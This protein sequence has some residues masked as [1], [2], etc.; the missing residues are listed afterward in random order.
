[1]RR[2]AAR[3]DGNHAEIRDTLRACGCSVADLSHVGGGVPDLLVGLRGRSYCIEV[4]NGALP[5]SRRR[6]TP[7]EEAW[8]AAWR[9]HYAVVETVDEALAVVGLR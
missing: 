8:R 1:M 3:T 5:P 9:G 7:D 2:R 4:K 6:L